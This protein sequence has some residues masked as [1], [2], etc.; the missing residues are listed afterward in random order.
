[1]SGWFPQRREKEK[2]KI[3]RFLMAFI[4]KRL[5][6]TCRYGETYTHQ[7]IETY[8]DHGKV[9]Q[10]VLAN[11]GRSTSVEEALAIARENLDFWQ[12]RPASGP[13]G[14]NWYTGARRRLRAKAEARHRDERTRDV[15]RYQAQ[16]DALESVVSRR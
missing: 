16:V 5:S 1:M 14:P 2:R 10:R 15:A 7:L 9:K 13:R 12:R 3:W 11:L 4:R 8:R 6:S